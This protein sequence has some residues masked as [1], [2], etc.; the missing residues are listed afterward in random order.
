MKL[1]MRRGDW[2]P[3]LSCIKVR[4]CLQRGADM[5]STF[6]QL[7]ARLRRDSNS[8]HLCWVQEKANNAQPRYNGT[9]PQQRQVL[10]QRK[11]LIILSLSGP[12]P[13]SYT[14]FLRTSNSNQSPQIER[15][16]V[17]MGPRASV[18]GAVTSA[19]RSLW[20]AD[21]QLYRVLGKIPC[22]VSA[23]ICLLLSRRTGR[24]VGDEM[25]LFVFT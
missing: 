8:P 21:V 23:F 15:A 24:G 12:A 14:V 4:D 22:E 10:V 19:S 3:L 9:F 5:G 16:S 25:R 13:S 1:T 7:K 17:S 6:P 18:E 2:T 11:N 20:A